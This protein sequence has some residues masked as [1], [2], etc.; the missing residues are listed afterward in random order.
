MLFPFTLDRRCPVVRRSAR[1]LRVLPARA[2]DDGELPA[3]PPAQ[4]LEVRR[5]LHE[6]HQRGKATIY[7]SNCFP[8]TPSSP[9]RSSAAAQHAGSEAWHTQS[10]G[11][12][13]S[14]KVI[15]ILPLPGQVQGG[16]S[17]DR[18]Q[19]A[20]CTQEGEILSLPSK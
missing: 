7:N 15:S 5:P 18:H 11:R 8:L 20:E 3:V 2:A 4:G 17:A 10:T 6:F 19:P 1:G 9:G 16:G 13:G 14:Y 12:F